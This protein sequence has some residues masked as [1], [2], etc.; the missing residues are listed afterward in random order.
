M[1]GS[2][3]IFSVTIIE[4]YFLKYHQFC[5]QTG[6]WEQVPGCILFIASVL[7]QILMMSVFGENIIT[8]VSEILFEN[9]LTLA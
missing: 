2:F 4:I 7:L 5:I 9:T 8:E 3:R 1:R 6:S